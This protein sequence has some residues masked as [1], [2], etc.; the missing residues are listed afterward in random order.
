M[1]D[2]VIELIL[3]IEKRPTMYIGDNSIFCLKAF[4]DGWH[5]RNPKNANNSQMLVEFT[6]WLQK[7]YDIGTYNVSWDKI[8]FFFYKDEKLALNKFFLDFNQ[9]LQDKSRP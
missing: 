1:Q 6:G 3:E 8:L 2:N 9:F 5:F 7:K 4:L